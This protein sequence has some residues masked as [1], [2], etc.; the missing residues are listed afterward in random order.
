MSTRVCL[1]SGEGGGGKADEDQ[2]AGDWKSSYKFDSLVLR[3]FHDL[4]KNLPRL[5]HCM[6]VKL[7]KRMVDACCKTCLPAENGGYIIVFRS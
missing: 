3:P 6:N 5:G 2:N 7:H 1:G 4:I